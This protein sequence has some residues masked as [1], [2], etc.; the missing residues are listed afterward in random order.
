MSMKFEKGDLVCHIHSPGTLC[1]E[2]TIMRDGPGGILRAYALQHVIQP[3][4]EGYPGLGGR[5]EIAEM[6]LRKAK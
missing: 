1:V 5:V 3:G 2:E 4:E 6:F